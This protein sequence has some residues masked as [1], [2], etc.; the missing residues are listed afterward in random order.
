[1]RIGIDARFYGTLGKGLGRYTEKLITH[2]ERLDQE[3]E[4]FVFL[5]D[6]NFS[7]FVPVNARFHP[8]RADYPWYGWREQFSFPFLLRQYRL[9]LMHF[10]HF[11][12]PVF[13]RRPFVVTIH[14]LILLHFPTIKATELSPLLYWFKYFL[15]R[16]VIA[17]AL[18]RAKKIFAVSHFTKQDI[19]SHFSGASTKLVVT[20]EGI[21]R[22]CVA[23]PPLEVQTIL[24][25]YRLSVPQD[26]RDGR[27]ERA[28]P[29]V[30]YV[31][32]A[33]PHKNLTLI[34]SLAQRFPTMLFV[35]VGR[36]D[37]FYHTLRKE[38]ERA[39]LTNVRFVGFVPDREL[40]VLYRCATLYLF[41]SLYEGF[42]LPALEACL[43][44][45]PVL[46]SD[47]GSLREV[48]D[49]AGEYFDPDRPTHSE[50]MMKS[51]LADRVRREHL[52]LRGF[53]RTL[54]FDW[55]TM[56]RDT[57]AAYIETTSKLS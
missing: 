56:A 37:Y 52:R 48:L 40:S 17:S 16:L 23:V 19:E 55:E 14:D 15:Y 31:G 57:R 33:Y 18:R 32:N 51:L 46:A 47:R 5:R 26:E 30:L 39:G 3:H 29:Y 13:Y 7:E 20:P 2:L 53:A 25:Q 34:L 6:E 54:H 12:V 4:Y 49:D 50:A 36:E 10:P 41:P 22:V 38:A 45:L 8:V 28:I 1:M 44:G 11:N 24:A 43:Y 21:D 9:D 35:L 27:Q 42:G